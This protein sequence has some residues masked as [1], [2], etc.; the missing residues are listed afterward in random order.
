M[1]V[2][3]DIFKKNAFLALDKLNFAYLVYINSFQ[4]ENNE[5]SFLDYNLDN[6]IHYKE[7]KKIYISLMCLII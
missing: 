6:N 4:D 3:N 7:L 1:A 5:Y 2:K